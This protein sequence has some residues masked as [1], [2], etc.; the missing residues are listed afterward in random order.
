MPAVPD[1]AVYYVPAADDPLYQR[2]TEILGYDARTGEFTANDA[3]ARAAFANFNPDWVGPAQEYGFHMTIGHAVRFEAERLGAIEAEIENILNVFDP[4][5][6]FVLTP[7]DPYIMPLG[8]DS[9]GLRFDA[10]MSLILLHALIIGRVHPLGTSTLFADEMA[11]GQY[12]DLPPVFAHRTRQY[13]HPLILDDWYPHLSLLR[14][15][16]GDASDDVITTLTQVMPRSEQVEVKT[17]CLLIKDEGA[18]H[19][20][21]VR[22]FARADYPH[23]IG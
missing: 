20:R 3:P 22:E 17:I 10:N 13:F 16:E 19:F 2:G 14:N 1:F 15:Y 11:T 9:F 4:S 6:P 23:R 5:K 12:P 8:I 7:C 21:V 18:S